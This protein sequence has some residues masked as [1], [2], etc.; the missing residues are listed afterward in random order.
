[1]SLDQSF[2]GFNF[3]SKFSS[4]GRT[5][6]PTYRPFFLFAGLITATNWFIQEHLAKLEEEQTKQIIKR[7]QENQTS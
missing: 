2:K 4:L 5:T 3:F 7:V 1:M 6:K